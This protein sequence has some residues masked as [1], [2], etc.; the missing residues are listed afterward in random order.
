MGLEARVV[1]VAAV[2]GFAG[3]AFA[4]RPAGVEPGSVELTAGG[5][6]GGGLFGPGKNMPDI[7]ATEAHFIYSGGLQLR[8]N[9]VFGDQNPDAEGFTA[10]LSVAGLLVGGTLAEGVSVVEWRPITLHLRPRLGRFFFEVP[11]GLTVVTTTVNYPRPAG[12]S[13]Y[14]ASPSTVKYSTSLSYSDLRVGLGAGYRW[15][16]IEMLIGFNVSLGRD[17]GIGTLSATVSYVFGAPWE[18]ARLDKDK[19]YASG[20][21]TPATEPPR[22]TTARET[23]TTTAAAPALAALLRPAAAAGLAGEYAAATETPGRP[24]KVA[25][26]PDG[27]YFEND[28]RDGSWSPAD[29]EDSGT[30]EIRADRRPQFTTAYRIL[31]GAPSCTAEGCELELNGVRYERAPA[32]SVCQTP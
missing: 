6:V 20:A 27:R 2:L 13:P 14:A 16:K 7:G 10:G 8:V 12:S 23:V 19:A 25:L 4:Q 3:Q 28:R 21:P 26:C 1:A 18:W 24:T 15:Q 9:K 17:V 29:L 22:A 11:L 30:L 5:L 32:P 31:R